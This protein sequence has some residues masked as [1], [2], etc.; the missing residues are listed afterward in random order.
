MRE[1]LRGLRRQNREQA[2]TIEVLRKAA[3]GLLREGER[4]MSDVY[5]FIEVE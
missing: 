3:V 5:A 1:E 4:S 2:E